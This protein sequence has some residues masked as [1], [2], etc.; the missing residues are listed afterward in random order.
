MTGVGGGSDPGV[1]CAATGEA[2]ISKNAEGEVGPDAGGTDAR[3]CEG[4]ASERAAAR[5]TLSAAVIGDMAEDT[6]A[7]V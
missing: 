2:V 3:L 1:P 5:E 4:I 6:E 7:G